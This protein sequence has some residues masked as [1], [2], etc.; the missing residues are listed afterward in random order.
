MVLFS[1]MNQFISLK[2]FSEILFCVD[3]T[4]FQLL[5]DYILILLER[6]KEVGSN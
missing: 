3:T 5:T 4:Y 2:S 1:N 6:W